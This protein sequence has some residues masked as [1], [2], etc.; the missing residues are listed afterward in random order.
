MSKPSFIIVE[1]RVPIQSFEDYAD[2]HVPLSWYP[3]FQSARKELAQV[4]KLI[5]AE[6][7]GY[8]SFPL[9]KDVFTFADLTPFEKIKVCIVGQDPYFNLDSKTKEPQAC[10][11]SFSVKNGMEIPPSLK[12]I[13]KEIKA[14]YPD[15]SR[16]FT[17]G[18][19]HGWA[20]Q[21]VLL[22]NAALTVTPGQP[23]SH[24]KFYQGFIKKVFDAIKVNNKSCI[25]CLWGN[26]AKAAAGNVSYSL[27]CTHP[28]PQSCYNNNYG[29]SFHGC[30][31]FL[32]V[33]EMLIKQGREPIDWFQHE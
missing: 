9:L 19:L 20:R 15:D 22:I 10:G 30:Q 25:W 33:N 11:L 14:N 28:S 32:R 3:V 7:S 12:N 24:R 6:T 21:G 13:F 23:N 18:C 29:Q 4:W 17:S 27:N 26:D 2:N 1:R 31:H 8:N 5:G 16:D